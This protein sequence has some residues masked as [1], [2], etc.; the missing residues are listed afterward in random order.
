M[1]FTQSL[2]I[3]AIVPDCAERRCHHT[4]RSGQ[5]MRL[6]IDNDDLEEPL[7]SSTIMLC[8]VSKALACLVLSRL[9]IC[10]LSSS[11]TT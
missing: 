1:D 10:F 8:E 4:V 9:C 2:E 6:E 3:N 7:Y 11:S 5:G